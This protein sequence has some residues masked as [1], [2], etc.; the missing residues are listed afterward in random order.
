M[1]IKIKASYAD[2]E[3]E[4]ILLNMFKPLS[5]AGAAVKIKPGKPYNHIYVDGKNSSSQ[6]RVNMV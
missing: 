4:K 2:N 3:E 1:S 5:R 6:K